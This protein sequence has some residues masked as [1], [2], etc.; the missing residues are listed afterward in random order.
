[1]VR[2]NLIMVFSGLI[3]IALILLVQLSLPAEKRAEDDNSVAACSINVD[4]ALLRE[5]ESSDERMPVIVIFQEGE[6]PA[7]DDFE[8]KHAYHLINGVSGYAS[9]STIEKLAAD[10]MVAGIYY[11]AKVTAAYP[12]EKFNN[13]GVSNSAK[14]VNADKL[15]AEGID[16]SG[17]IV[18]VLD[19][20]IYKN[21]PDLVGSVIGE[22]NFVENEKTTDDLLGHGTMCAGLIAGTGVASGGE[23]MGIAPGASLLN[24]RVIDSDGNGQVSDIIAGIEWALDNDADVLSLSLAGINLGETNPP[25]SMAADNAMDAGA[26]VCVAAGNRG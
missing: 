11:D 12:A 25:V 26:V 13:S 6:R 10:E 19:S 18:A 16:G 14:I 24:V 8:I 21:H 3:L 15:W 22:K 4:S 1:M 7:L 5:M 23:Y 9:P 20:G 2:Q 17:V